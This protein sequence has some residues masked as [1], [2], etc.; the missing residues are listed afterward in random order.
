MSRP[1]RLEFEG[2]IYHVVARG[3]ERRDIF[4]DDRDREK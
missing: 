1:V 3:N 2:G 4:R